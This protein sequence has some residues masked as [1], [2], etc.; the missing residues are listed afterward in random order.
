[1]QGTGLNN[2]GKPHDIY[3]STTI[4]SIRAKITADLFTTLPGRVPPSKEAFTNI[5]LM[6]ELTC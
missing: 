2:G 1:M 4:H 5:L 3:V 6:N